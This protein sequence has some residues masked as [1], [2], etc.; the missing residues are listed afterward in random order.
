MSLVCA[1]LALNY[2]AFK[3]RLAEMGWYNRRHLSVEISPA[4]EHQHDGTHDEWKENEK[5]KHL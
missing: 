5:Q 1:E 3:C 2:E 4:I